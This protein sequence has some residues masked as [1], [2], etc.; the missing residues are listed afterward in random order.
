MPTLEA[1]RQAVAAVTEVRDLAGSDAV[2]G[3][4]P[5]RVACPATPPRSLR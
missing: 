5:G 1:G 2:D 3:V 4:P